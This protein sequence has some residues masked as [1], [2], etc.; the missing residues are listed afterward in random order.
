MLVFKRLLQPSLLYLA[1]YT[2]TNILYA[3]G[4]IK[5]AT[6]AVLECFESKIKVKQKKKPTWNVSKFVP[7]KKAQ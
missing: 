3:L 6:S 7:K 4:F 1:Y 5:A 2:Y